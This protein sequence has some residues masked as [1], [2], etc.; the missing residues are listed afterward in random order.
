MV[1]RRLRSPARRL[2]AAPVDAFCPG[3]VIAVPALIDSDGPA[4]PPIVEPVHR[5]LAP[6]SV[7]DQRLRDV[8]RSTD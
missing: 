3:E 6:E 4:E 2:K 8:E 7:P 5:I 1:M